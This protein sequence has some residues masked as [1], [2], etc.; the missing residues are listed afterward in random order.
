MTEIEEG[1]LYPCR[2]GY[3][4]RVGRDWGDGTLTWVLDPIPPVPLT[5][6]GLAAAT[7]TINAFIA[8]VDGA[9]N[10]AAREQGLFPL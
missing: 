5:H 6:D 2:D 8:M 1:G 4:R 10:A 7:C 9:A 3:V